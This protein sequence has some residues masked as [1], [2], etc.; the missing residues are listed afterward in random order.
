M[1]QKYDFSTLLQLTILQLLRCLVRI[2][3][4]ALEHPPTLITTTKWLWLWL[5][6]E[7]WQAI[8]L[9][10][11][12]GPV[13]LNSVNSVIEYQLVSLLKYLPM[14]DRFVFQTQRIINHKPQITT[15]SKLKI[16]QRWLWLNML[17]YSTVKIQCLPPFTVM[18]GPPR[19]VKTTK[20]AETKGSD[21]E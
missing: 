17:K 19:F 15:V 1:Q 21:D 3:S 2:L 20:H 4:S 18:N 12:C 5:R 13:K 11:H 9:V 8:E 6:S 14:Q 16:Q 10:W 7:M